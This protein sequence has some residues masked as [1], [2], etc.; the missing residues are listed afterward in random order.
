MQEA[1]LDNSSPKPKQYTN[2]SKGFPSPVDS[3][4]LITSSRHV[5]KCCSMGFQMYTHHQLFPFFGQ[6]SAIAALPFLAEQHQELEHPPVF[7]TQEVPSLL[8]RGRQLTST[9]AIQCIFQ[10]GAALR[11]MFL[12]QNRKGFRST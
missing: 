2:L 1:A 6:C 4:V 8:R 5:W 11:S 7:L 3:H 12:F 9:K 10:T